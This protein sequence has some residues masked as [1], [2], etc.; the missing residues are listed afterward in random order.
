[1]LLNLIPINKCIFDYFPNE[2][3]IL[4]TKLLPVDDLAALLSCEAFRNKISALFKVIEVIPSSTTKEQSFAG[5]GANGSFFSMDGLERM[6]VRDVYNRSYRKTNQSLIYLIEVFSWDGFD[7]DLFTY[8]FQNTHNFMIIHA[9]GKQTID[10]RNVVLDVYHNTITE[11]L[12]SFAS[13]TLILNTPD[14]DD[15]IIT[16]KNFDPNRLM[17]TQ[18]VERL[19]MCGASA[20]SKR[21]GKVHMNNVWEL[22]LDGIPQSTIDAVDYTNISELTMFLKLGI[23]EGEEPILFPRNDQLVGKVAYSLDNVFLKDLLNI[24]LHWINRL[25]NINLPRL[26]QLR[27][28]FIEAAGADE[29]GIFNFTSESL[30]VLHLSFYSS[31]VCPMFQNV[32][33]PNLR[34]L[35]FSGNCHLDTSDSSLIQR[36]VNCFP[37]LVSLEVFQLPKMMH[38]FKAGLLNLKYL[39]TS[40]GDE[41]DSLLLQSIDL[42]SLERLNFKSHHPTDS[43]AYPILKAPKLSGF[44]LSS[45][46]SNA[47]VT[48]TFLGLSDAYPNLTILT[49]DLFNV[50]Y[51][52]LTQWDLTLPQVRFL[53]ITG[54]LFNIFEGLKTVS[55][56]CLEFCQ[57]IFSTTFRGEVEYHFDLNAPELKTLHFNRL[58]MFSGGN[59]RLWNMEDLNM[60]GTNLHSRNDTHLVV[61]N[62][63]KLIRLSFDQFFNEVTVKNCQNLKLIRGGYSTVDLR[64]ITAENLPSLKYLDI[65]SRRMTLERYREVEVFRNVGPSIFRKV[66]KSI[67]DRGYPRTEFV[68]KELFDRNELMEFQYLTFE[69]TKH[70]DSLVRDCIHLWVNDLDLSDLY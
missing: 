68:P 35:R 6:S 22:I 64:R 40:V 55:F 11:V 36:N 1:M 60:D 53:G 48:K 19:T 47:S 34:H 59:G 66:R 54:P 37:N 18:P 51:K 26:R 14:Y 52:G 46:S 61:Q 24:N 33:F 49:L 12:E 15:H 50:N 58:G 9:I 28:K 38:F 45:I 69:G 20:A 5:A 63:P 10:S 44:T 23:E 39:N 21:L 25:S 57:M 65:N 17:I 42:P 7:L 2:I 62:Y 43:R 30:K 13:T 70:F 41:E 56:P 16:A 29:M 32:T 31:N 8:H 27:A 4:I 67:G 3:L